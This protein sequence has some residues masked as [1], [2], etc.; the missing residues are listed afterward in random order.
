MALL[1]FYCS[2]FRKKSRPSGSH[3]NFCSQ[4]LQVKS[5]IM[6]YLQFVLNSERTLWEGTRD[7]KTGDRRAQHYNYSSEKFMLCLA[8]MISIDQILA[9]GSFKSCSFSG[10]DGPQ[11]DGSWCQ[12]AFLLLFLF[13]GQFRKRKLITIRESPVELELVHIL[14]VAPYGNVYVEII[15]RREEKRMVHLCHPHEIRIW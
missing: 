10:S 14:F 3:S 5:N 13:G 11:L 2:Y 7:I 4:V 15:F 1:L 8:K 12:Q 9:S 6:K